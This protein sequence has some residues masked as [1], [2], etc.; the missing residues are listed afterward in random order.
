MV[1][2]GGGRDVIGFYSAVEGERLTQAALYYQSVTNLLHGHPIGIDILSF[3]Y[4]YL[5]VLH[6][7]LS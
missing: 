7:R 1:S 2:D 5:F 4:G 3:V 6:G